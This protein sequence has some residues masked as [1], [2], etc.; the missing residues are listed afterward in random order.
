M[1]TVEEVLARLDGVE[2]VSA[3][4]ATDK[5]ALVVRS[6]V[7]LDEAILNRALAGTAFRV[8]ELERRK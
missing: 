4:W 5:A 8:V 1:A 6:G 2:Q 7:V 3:G